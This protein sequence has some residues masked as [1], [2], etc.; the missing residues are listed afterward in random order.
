M[1]KKFCDPFIRSLIVHKDLELGFCHKRAPMSV[2]FDFLKTKLTRKSSDE[3][4]CEDDD[5]FALYNLHRRDDE[6]MMANTQLFNKQLITKQEY[7]AKLYAKIK[8]TNEKEPFAK[9]GLISYFPLFFRKTGPF[10]TTH[11]HTV[12]FLTLGEGR[13]TRQFILYQHAH[14]LRT[15]G[16]CST[17]YDI[18]LLN[19]NDFLVTILDAPETENV[20]H[21][22]DEQGEFSCEISVTLGKSGKMEKVFH[23]FVDQSVPR[24]LAG[25]G[26][27]VSETYFEV[28]RRSLKLKEE[29]LQT[30]C[31]FAQE[32]ELYNT[33]DDTPDSIEQFMADISDFPFSVP[34][35]VKR[36]I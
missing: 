3:E 26:T 14:L 20:E 25:E 7:L 15:S 6:K 34:S 28:T 5:P 23:H 29:Q 36:A 35:R 24:Y 17:G 18:Y 13:Q 27:N 1:A 11:V 30:I 31:N 22:C 21:S 12:L 19:E 2:V 8:K 4:K 33:W 16:P 10:H 9:S 32:V